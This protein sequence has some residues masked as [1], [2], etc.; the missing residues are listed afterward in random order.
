[1]EK[2]KNY[3]ETANKKTFLDIGTGAGNF[4]HF[5]KSMY[6]GFDTMIGIDVFERVID[7]AKKNNQDERVTF[8]VMDKI[9]FK[10]VEVATGNQVNIIVS[11]KATPTT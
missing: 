10:A 11:V 2:L 5:I 4:I 6:D 9:S 3:L 1:M 7:M 8:E